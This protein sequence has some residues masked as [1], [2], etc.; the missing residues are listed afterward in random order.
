MQHDAVAARRR[1]NPISSLDVNEDGRLHYL[2]LL[3]G[4]HRRLRPRTYVEIG[5]EHGPSM[6]L[7]LPGTRAIG[8]DP[9]PAIRWPTPRDCRIYS[10]ESDQFFAEHRLGDL[11]GGLPTDL[12]FIDGMHLF[13][14]ALRDFSNIERS[15]TRGSVVLLHDCLPIDAVTAARERTT[16]VW[17]GDVW[18]FIVLLR[19]YRPDLSVATVDAPPT[20][21]AIVTNLDPAST[22]LADR[23][24]EIIGEYRD[25]PFS[26]IEHDKREQ[27]A[28]V[29]SDW[30][31]V[32]SLLPRPFR[33]TNSTLLRVGRAL[34]WPTREQLRRGV[35]TP[36]RGAV[37]KLRRSVS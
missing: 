14:Y 37:R 25:L 7:A 28:V 32:D 3:D 36:V 29:P 5:V 23:Y 11:F 34:R 13:E 21:L 22:V 16:N 31:H 20:G 24:D 27:L 17:S 2:D 19:R 33:R 10:L 12:A 18:K 4:I 30:H 6:R 9:A 15:A 35:P 26:A 1:C 8:I